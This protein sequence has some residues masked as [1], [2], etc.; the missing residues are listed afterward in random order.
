MPVSLVLFWRVHVPL[1]R[2]RTTRA[3]FELQTGSLPTYMAHIWLLLPQQLRH[4]RHPSTLRLG[5][6]TLRP[7]YLGILFH[8]PSHILCCQTREDLGVT[9]SSFQHAQ[10][11]LRGGSSVDIQRIPRLLKSQGTS[12]GAPETGVSLYIYFSLY[13]VPRRTFQ[14]R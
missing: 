9:I 13:G 10:S 5:L 6:S 2:P 3:S 12:S 1:P 11:V 14:I 8:H 7:L 4:R